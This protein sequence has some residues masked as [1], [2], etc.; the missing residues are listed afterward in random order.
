MTFPHTPY[1]TMP[2]WQEASFW[3]LWG[4]RA[5]ISRL[6]GLPLPSTEYQSEGVPF[7][8][9]GAPHPHPGTQSAIEK[10]VRD[11]AE[12]L[13]KA[14]YGYRPSIGFQANRLLSPVEGP[15]YGSDMNTFAKDTPTTPNNPTR[16]TREYERRGGEA[17]QTETLE[18]S[19]GVGH[20]A[21]P[22][23][24]VQSTPLI[25]ATA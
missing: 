24:L 5:I 3:N 18:K 1:D 11:N 2:W 19:N 8:A 22:V 10:K 23:L 9:M 12:V 17:P 25:S 14:P 15:T 16:F 21:A 4:P 13:E 6:R 7:E 20:I